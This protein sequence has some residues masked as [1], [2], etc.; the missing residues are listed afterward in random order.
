LSR[1]L[2]KTVIRTVTPDRL[3]ITR[4]VGA[5]RFFDFAQNDI[6]NIKVIRVRVSRHE[7]LITNS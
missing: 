1:D 3:D 5:L 6:L 7:F 4:K 2:L